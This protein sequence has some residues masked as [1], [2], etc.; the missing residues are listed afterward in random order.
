[1]LRDN[2]N[3]SKTIF[4]LAS[5]R[6][7]AAVAIVKM[8]GP[9]AFLFASKIFKPAAGGALELKRSM[10]WGTLSD[11]QGSKIDDCLT[12]V[13]VGPNSHT[14]ENAI[15]FQCHGSVP[16]VRK[17]E[18]TLIELGAHPAERGEF[19]YRAHLNGRISPAEIESLGDVFLA[20]EQGDLRKIYSRKDGSLTQKILSLRENLIRVQAILD[21]AIDFADEYSNVVGQAR[22][23]LKMTIH[24][25][26]EI[27]QRYSTFKNAAAVSRLVIAGKPNAGKSSLFNA[28][29][30]HYRAI[31]HEEA[32]TTRD[33]IEED[34]EVGGQRWKLVDTAGFRESDEAREKEGIEIG[35]RFLA[36][37]QFWILVVDG[38]SG[39]THEEEA[40]IEKYR[41][42]P[43][44]VVWN[45]KDLSAWREPSQKWYRSSV[46]PL[47]AQTG[48]GIVELW[49]KLD[50]HLSSRE[51]PGPLPTAVESQRLITALESM[52][53]L[54]AALERGENP[55]SL[56]E[57][58]REAVRTLE[59]VVGEVGIEDVLDR[60]FGEFCIG[61]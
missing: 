8:S 40:L 14:G 16:V 44:L 33:V 47:S 15:E 12:L 25:C 6:L 58:N 56:S 32:G 22:S 50:L 11:V 39:I 60:V 5:G 7:P 17:L 18:K 48:E 13:F 1:V 52:R 54:L 26:S 23:P 36:S 19:S 35:E 24:E 9:D 2:L 45:K 49:K 34:M 43:H 30:G 59:A 61:K 3:L 29:L 21:T 37:S 38:S 4:A 31:V 51:S 27:I 42:K 20:R 41:S 10:V 55:E 53:T 57:K 46:H 28:L